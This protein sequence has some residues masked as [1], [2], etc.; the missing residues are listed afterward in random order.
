MHLVQNQNQSR[1]SAASDSST[2]E[3][4][5][6]APDSPLPIDTTTGKPIPET[7]P[8][9]TAAGEHTQLGTKKSSNRGVGE[10]TQGREFDAS[11]NRIR[12]IDFTDHG[13]KDHP[14]PHQHKIDP[15]TGKRLPPEELLDP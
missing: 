4:G 3:P 2:A 14:N 7:N 13:R 6:Y 8:D 15:K 1:E 5:S 12:D 10:Y 9:G 11:G